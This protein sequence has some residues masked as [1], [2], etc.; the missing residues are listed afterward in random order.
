[1][2]EGVL[3][4]TTIFVL[5][6]A[7]I[8]GILVSRNMIRLLICVETLFNAILL[9]IVA[10]GAS[11]SRLTSFGLLGLMAIVLTAVEV[12]VLTAVLVLL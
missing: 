10:V 5:M 6:V 12:A 3:I 4:A 2:I 9:S 7:G 1:M 8:Y 11:T